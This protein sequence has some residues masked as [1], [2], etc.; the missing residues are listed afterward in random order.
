M[1]EGGTVVTVYSSEGRGGRGGEG[2]RRGGEGEGRGG[3]GRGRERGGAGERGRGKRPYSGTGYE[4]GQYPFVL[5]NR[6]VFCDIKLSRD[7]NSPP[8]PRNGL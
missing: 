6:A 4:D 1:G 7:W 2:R 8:P 3:E 5:Y